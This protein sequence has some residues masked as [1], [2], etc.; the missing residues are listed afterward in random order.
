M[1]KTINKI[2]K[3]IKKLLLLVAVCAII[4]GAYL[5]NSYVNAQ[6]VSIENPNI[7]KVEA[8]TSIQT[9]TDKAVAE[10]Q[11]RIDKERNQLLIEI[12]VLKTEQEVKVARLKALEGVNF[13][14]ESN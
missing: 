3:F 5:A 9:E 7:P 1:K 10:A 8:K 11:A 13:T 14:K 12:E 2:V 6:K 4:Y